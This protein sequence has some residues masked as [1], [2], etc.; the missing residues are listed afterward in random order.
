MASKLGVIVRFLL[1]GVVLMEIVDKTK[2]K[3][4]KLSKE[5][6][7]SYWALIIKITQN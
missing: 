7:V 1:M 5:L 4:I 3:L 6:P 2:E